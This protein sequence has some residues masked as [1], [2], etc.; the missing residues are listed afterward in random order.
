MMAST[1][2]T[3]Q[4]FYFEFF[5]M[6]TIVSLKH[7]NVT[8]DPL[9][10][11]TLM[12]SEA[13]TLNILST[14]VIRDLTAA[15]RELAEVTD[16][17]VLIFRGSENKA[18]VAGAN[19]H[20]MAALTRTSAVTF[21]SNLRDLCEATRLFP[22]PV[23]ARIPGWCLGGGLELAMACDV[24]IAAHGTQF[25]MPEVKVGIPSVIHATLMPRLIGQARATWL[26][27]SG[28]NIDAEQA[29]HW[30]LINET[31]ALEALDQRVLAIAH[32]FAALGTAA[33][34]QQKTLLRR[35]EQ[36]SLSDAITDSVQEFGKAFE[37]GEPQKFM[38]EFLAHKKAKNR[39]EV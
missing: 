7:A 18:F 10:V 31:V 8:I 39:P 3:A 2:F 28:E 20:E 19:I 14:P 16:I 22:V 11:A 38:N 36:L 4:T 17:R 29:L 13:G 25:G 15:L 6:K 1:P 24:R 23:I 34:R 37:T 30:G 9:G 12:I 32:S 26:L 21:I 35:W 27:L 33:L 5:N